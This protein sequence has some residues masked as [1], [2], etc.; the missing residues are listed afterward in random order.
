MKKMLFT[1]FAFSGMLAAD[2][3][4]FQHTYGTPT[5]ESPRSGKNV[6]RA[7]YGQV[8]AG[9]TNNFTGALPTD[10][11]L[12]RSDNNGNVPAAPFFNNAYR[13]TN[14]AGAQL[15]TQAKRVIE[16]TTG[17]FFVVGDYGNTTG[18]TPPGI[19][20]AVF[21]PGGVVLA[22]ESYQ[23][24]VPVGYIELTSVR[25]S[26]SDSKSVFACGFAYD[27][28]SGNVYLIAMRMSALTAKITWANTYAINGTTTLHKDRAMD[29]I[30]SPY[31]PYGVKEVVV[32]GYTYDSTVQPDGFFL[33]LASATGA[34][35]TGFTQLYST[36]KDD[37]FNAIEIANN[38]IGSGADY[39][40]SGFT[41]GYS[42]MGDYD[43]WTLKVSTTGAAVD[44][45]TTH[46]YSA[47]GHN[48]R[49]YD[50][51]ER[52][53][54]LGQWEYYVPGYTDKGFIGANDDVVVDKLNNAGV[55]TAEF[56][57]GGAGMDRGFE[58]D[59]FA[60]GPLN[61]TPGLST[62][63]VTNS[64][65]NP[66]FTGADDAYLVKSYFNGRSGCNE[67]FSTPISSTHGIVPFAKPVYQILPLQHDT[68]YNTAVFTMNDKQLCYNVTIGG[69]SNA[70]IANPEGDGSST[71]A[72]AYPNPVDA[73]SP[74]VM[75]DYNGAAD[76][77][78][79][80]KLVDITGRTCMEQTVTI[81][82]GKQ[83]L[84]IDLGSGLSTG[85]YQLL[86]MDG[87]T[88]TTLRVAVK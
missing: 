1:L 55:G 24:A 32:V 42:G 67:F 18:T 54:T 82:E 48:E 79:Q 86:L 19:Y 80:V 30:E 20:G 27:N 71:T 72:N 76:G 3:Q 15:G 77:T 22:A 33:E 11:T 59:Q 17:N 65:P 8:M 34:P 35:M 87:T 14:A 52:R 13:F 26:L 28:A 21:S 83:T 56:T 51:I 73:S 40:V 58:C 50:I 61:P 38:P 49:A 25:Q 12:T 60:V 23:F 47:G 29:I 70:R 84:S 45:E 10:M 62:F 57:Y 66:P 78:I 6:K 68:M 75:V 63:G 4:Y 46:D 69:G 9:G 81:F 41:N 43:Y 31:S 39:V 2:A 74:T 88:T 37:E 64:F 16:L 53:N 7:P 44:W 5:M 85:I 36:P